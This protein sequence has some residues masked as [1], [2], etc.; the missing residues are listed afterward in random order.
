MGGQG[1]SSSGVQFSNTPRRDQR[2][3]NSTSSTNNG[4]Q[5]ARGQG[6][7]RAQSNDSDRNYQG[8]ESGPGSAFY[9]GLSE[10]AVSVSNPWTERMYRG[11]DR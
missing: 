6:Q 7:G 3:T 10:G 8:P 11:Q 1:S 9:S 5:M 2:S 4:N